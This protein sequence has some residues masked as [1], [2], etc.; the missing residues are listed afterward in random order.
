MAPGENKKKLKKKSLFWVYSELFARL[1]MMPL[2]FFYLINN[3]FKMLYDMGC[4]YG[5]Y[6]SVH[7]VPTHF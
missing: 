5:L 6:F 4:I 2:I 3:Q 1:P 7:I